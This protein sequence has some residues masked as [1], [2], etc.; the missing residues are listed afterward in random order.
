[1]QPMT[2]SAVTRPETTNVRPEAAK[3]LE[4]FSAVPPFWSRSG[5]GRLFE[6]RDR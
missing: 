2:L 4:I 5:T 3:A 6:N 1:M